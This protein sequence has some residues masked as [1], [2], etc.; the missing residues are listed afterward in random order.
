V[1]VIGDSFGSLVGSLTTE[2]DLVDQWFVHLHMEHLLANLIGFLLISI[3]I[4][5]RCLHK[6]QRTKLTRS[7]F[8]IEG[9]A[10][11]DQLTVHSRDTHFM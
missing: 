8:K 2:S 3:S 1:S 10:L 6:N 7:V 4:N 9:R 11:S 5:F